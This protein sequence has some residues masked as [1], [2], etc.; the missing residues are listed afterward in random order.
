MNCENCAISGRPKNKIC[1]DCRLIYLEKQLTYCNNNHSPVINP[2]P[3]EHLECTECPRLVE[4]INELSILL[5]Q[6]EKS[7]AELL[8]QTQDHI[9]NLIKLEKE[10]LKKKIDQLSPRYSAA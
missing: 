6:S 8:S 1:K 2:L 9:D 4:R 7:K 10:T 3:K 5:M